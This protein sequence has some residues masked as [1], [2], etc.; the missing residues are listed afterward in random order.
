[1]STLYFLLLFWPKIN[2]DPGIDI[3]KLAMYIFNVHP[4]GAENIYIILK[5]HFLPNEKMHGSRFLYRPIRLIMT[6][7]HHPNGKILPESVS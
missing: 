1:L 4:P 2:T 7:I 6:L 3:E 5:L